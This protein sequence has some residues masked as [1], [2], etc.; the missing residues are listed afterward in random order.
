MKKTIAGGLTAVLLTGGIGFT[1]ASAEASPSPMTVTGAPALALPTNLCGILGP[2]LCN[3][4]VLGPL[5]VGVDGALDDLL[6][7]APEGIPLS[8]SQLADAISAALAAT[9]GPQS[10]QVTDAI[11]ALL[12]NA[13]LPDS[14]LDQVTGQLGDTP[15]GG[16][17][18]AVLKT[19]EDLLTGLLGIGGQPVDPAAVQSQL[20]SILT[21]LASGDATALRTVLETL[22]KSLPGGTSLDPSTLTGLVDTLA[23]TVRNAAAGTPVEPIVNLITVTLNPGAA[24]PTPAATPSATPT[25]SAIPTYVTTVRPTI[26]GGGTPGASVTVRTS[27]GEVLGSTTVSASGA[28]AVVSK[29]LKRGAYTVSA[30]QVSPGL[31]TSASSAAQSFRVVSGSPVITTKANKRFSTHR[32]KITGVGYPKAKIVLRTSSGTKLGTARVRSNGTWS[33]KA[34]RL[35]SGTKKIKAIQ[36]GHDKKR[37]SKSKKIRIR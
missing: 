27:R 13:G 17:V 10:T 16:P 22:L 20:Q 31:G 23:T 30:T 5:L 37:T 11:A 6:N 8:A 4:S 12:A 15:A 1:S 24:T 33:I 2:V 18:A 21:S 35:S 3:A 26:S 7:S 28:F 14:V 34:K 9:S 36:T 19:I 29:K 32:P 25:I